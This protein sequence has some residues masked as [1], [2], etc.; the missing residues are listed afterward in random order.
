MPKKKGVREIRVS[1]LN[2]D[3][4]N[5]TDSEMINWQTSDLTE[6]PLTMKLSDL[7][8]K[9]NIKSATVEP[10]SITSLPCHTQGVERLIRAVNKASEKVYGAEARDAYIRQQLQSRTRRKRSVGLHQHERHDSLVGSVGYIE[11][12]Y[13]STF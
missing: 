1:M 6:P 3:A 11:A 9:G 10:Y 4:R 5:C 13:V 2:T 7:E 8:I 12:T